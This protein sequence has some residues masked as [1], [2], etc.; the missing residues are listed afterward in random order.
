MPAPDP[1]LMEM[2]R[3]AERDVDHQVARLAELARKTEH[4]TT[5]GTALVGAEVA[6]YAYVASQGIGSPV[7]RS[8]FVAS[9]SAALIALAVLLSTYVGFR[10]RLGVVVGPGGAWLAAKVNEPA[11]TPT[12]HLVALIAAYPRY[13]DENARILRAVHASQRGAL[14]ALLAS[15]ALAAGG[16]LYVFA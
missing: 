16:G 15:T 12:E 6:A 7:G 9:A 3:E 4:L 11:W 8:L 10:H 13:M 14:V 5:V 1:F 2:L